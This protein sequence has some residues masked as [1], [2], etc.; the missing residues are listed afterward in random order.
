MLTSTTS[1]LDQSLWQATTKKMKSSQSSS[2]PFKKS[3]SPLSQDKIRTKPEHKRFDQED[4]EPEPPRS[5]PDHADSVSPPPTKCRRTSDGSC[6]KRSVKQE[7]ITPKSQ[8]KEKKAKTR[9][10][11]ETT[12]KKEG[13]SFN[14]WETVT[15]EDASQT[16]KFLRLMGCKKQA[17]V[18]QKEVKETAAPQKEPEPYDPTEPTEDAVLPKYDKINMDLEK[19][20]AQAQP[21]RRGGLGFGV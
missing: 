10:L 2:E 5:P 1:N 14:K 17:T 11:S 13:M 7:S 21:R 15:L 3:L 12:G 19:Q 6:Q 18:P 16:N 9:P 8:E 4:E 20:F